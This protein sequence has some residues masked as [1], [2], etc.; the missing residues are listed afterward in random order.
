MNI[1]RRLS[2]YRLGSSLFSAASRLPFPEFMDFHTKWR[3]RLCH[4]LERDPEHRLGRTYY[5]L[6]RVIEE[7]RT[8]F[9]NPAVLAAYLLPRTS[10]SDGGQSPVTVVTSHQPDLAALSAFCLECLD[11]P[12]DSL[13]QRLMGAHAGTVI[14]ALLQ[15][16]RLVSTPD[17]SVHLTVRCSCRVR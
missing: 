9:P 4:V 6:A 17:I 3:K 1:A 5:E 7:E 15:V 10:W 8:E 14:R 12:L 16:S 2:E 13:Q 11:W